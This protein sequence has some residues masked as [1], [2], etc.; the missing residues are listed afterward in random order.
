MSDDPLVTRLRELQRIGELAGDCADILEAREWEAHGHPSV[1]ETLA[2][3]TSGL[4]AL[5]RHIP[6]VEA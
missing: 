4:E 3:I 6:V 2:G 1:R 5:A